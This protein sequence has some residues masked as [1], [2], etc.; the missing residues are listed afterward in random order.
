V[1]DCDMCT[2]LTSDPVLTPKGGGSNEC[3]NGKVK[4]PKR[5]RSA[6]ETLLHPSHAPAA[7]LA[8]KLHLL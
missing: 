6:G 7:S 3:N 5:R 4:N 1:D 8:S 2:G